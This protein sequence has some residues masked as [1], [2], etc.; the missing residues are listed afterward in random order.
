MNNDTQQ[1][2]DSFDAEQVLNDIRTSRATI[3]RRRYTKSKLDRYRAELVS[4]KNAGASLSD[5]VFWLRKT[6]R[7]KAQRTTVQRYLLKLP[8]MQAQYKAE[9]DNEKNPVGE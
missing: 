2:M 9:W 8:E 6:K 4:L 3:R 5:L 1:N 7:T